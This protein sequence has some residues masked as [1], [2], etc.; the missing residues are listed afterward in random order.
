M[1]SGVKTCVPSVVVAADVDI[2]EKGRQPQVGRGHGDLRGGPRRAGVSGAVWTAP[3]RWTISGP[4]WIITVSP[5]PL[6]RSSVMAMKPRSGFEADSRFWPM[7]S[8]RLRSSP[9]RTG[10]RPAHLVHARRAHRSDVPHEAIVIEPHA[11]GRRL[12]PRCREAA[13]QRAGRRRLVEM[14]RL[15]I[16][17]LRKGDDRLARRMDRAGMDHLARRDVLEGAEFRH[18][19]AN[20]KCSTS[21]SAT[22][23]SLPSSRNFPASRAPAS[24]L[25]AT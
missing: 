10:T 24:P 16:V 13:E 12:P 8:S 6:R 22:T 5:A 1:R 11:E 9:G 18:Q 23:Y 21:P 15:G 20:R 25:P 2:I 4:R 17:H 7:V 14:K 3:R 19:F